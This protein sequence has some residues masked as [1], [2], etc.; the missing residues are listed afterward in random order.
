MRFLAFGE[1]MLRLT[2]EPYKMLS[3]NPKLD[4][5]FTGTGVNVLAGLYLLKHEGHLISALPDNAIGRA[6]AAQLRHLGIVDDLLIF[7][8]NHI[9]CYFMEMGIAQ[10]ASQITYLNRSESAFNQAHY[11]FEMLEEAMRG[12]DAIHFC[13]ISLAQ[14]MMMANTVL[15]L[16]EKAKSLGLKVIFDCNYRP[17]LWTGKDE[18]TAQQLYQNMMDMADIAFVSSKDALHL[19]IAIEGKKEQEIL[20]AI[21]EKFHLE[22][23]FGTRRFEHG[24]QGYL[25][26]NRNYVESRIYPLEIYDRIGAGDAFAAGA[27]HGYFNGWKAEETIDFATASGVLA[28]ST[29]GDSP[30]LTLEEINDFRYYGPKDV[31]R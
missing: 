4:M 6:A 23:L 18:Q 19:G 17:S 7:E 10:R 24:Y 29:Y 3:Q 9:G 21:W 25:I 2:C 15:K 14:N 5:L 26:Q 22:A 11:D 31:R 28:H 12:F 1:V 16:A 20:T 30:L 8:G 27:L 13:G